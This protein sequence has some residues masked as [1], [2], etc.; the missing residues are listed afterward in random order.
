MPV[1][2]WRSKLSEPGQTLLFEAFVTNQGSR[3]DTR[4]VEDARRAVEA[5]KQGMRRPKELTSAI[6]EPNSFNL[7][8]AM[9][10]QTGWT[11]DPRVLSCP[12]L[13]VKA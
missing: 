2:D 1:C 11:K 6:D 12:C 9:L 5:F 10:L 4:H 13:V 8:G 3:L 7:L